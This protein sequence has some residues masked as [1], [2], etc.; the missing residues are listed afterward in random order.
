LEPLAFEALKANLEDKKLE[1]VK[2]W[3]EFAG[4]K[5]VEGNNQASAGGITVVFPGAVKEER[6]VTAEFERARD[7]AAGGGDAL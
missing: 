1:A 2:V 3:A 6:V 5:N 7:D 4:V